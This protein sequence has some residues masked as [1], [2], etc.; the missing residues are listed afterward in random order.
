MQR[1]AS[2]STK[3]RSSSLTRRY[4]TLAPTSQVDQTLFGS[5]KP[6][7]KNEERETIQIITRDLIRNLR[8]PSKDPSGGSI[9]LPSAEF[10]RITSTSQILPKEERDTQREAYQRKKEEEIRAAEETKRLINEAGLSHQENQA[11]TELELEA[12]DR[13]QRLL[14]QANASRMEEEEE[15]RKLN[16]LILA[17]QCQAM[18]DAQIDEKKQIQ[19]ELSEDEKRL[20]AMMEVE[21]RKALETMEQIDELHRQQR[22]GGMQNICDQIQQ[23]LIDK[24][25][26]DEMR[27]QEKEQTQEKQE[28]MNLED[29]KAMEKKRE[30]QQCL[31]EEIMRIN[32]ETMRAKELRRE[33]EKLAD[34]RNMEYMRNKMMR[35]AEYEAEQ[36]RM[37]KEKEVEIARLRARQEKAKDYKSEQIHSKHHLLSIEV[38]REK[39][40]YERVLK[41]QQ[42]AIIK[43]KAEEEKHQQ[44]A[45][46][47][48][49]AIR[50]QV[51][52]Q[53]LSAVAQ[54]K[55]IFK[56]ANQFVEVARQRRVRLN[57]IK[58]KKLK[59]LK[60]TG[61]SEKYCSEVERKA[62]ACAL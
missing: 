43:Q 28:K 6:F 58:E 24:Q 41:A 62:R 23:H 36:R 27:E 47:H 19:A 39:A 60:A 13:A 42:E 34:T 49:D 11:P 30:E 8:I 31:Q 51:K 17:A 54:R 12:R 20:D 55:E 29:L 4:R 57:D 53:E 61:L 56:E 46:R 16:M 37:K 45:R 7:R 35:E 3:S 44:K 32:T 10:Q 50:N 40:E 9:I 33:E 48:A 59:E 22:I 18:R 21:R 14:E 26:Q 25:M 52:E 5:P 38:G 15:I 2:S 1:R